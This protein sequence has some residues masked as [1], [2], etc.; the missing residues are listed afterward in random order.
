[1]ICNISSRLQH[2]EFIH[3]HKA[4]FSPSDHGKSFFNTP[5]GLSLQLWRLE[6]F[7]SLDI[8]KRRF[9][10]VLQKLLLI[11]IT[12]MNYCLN[13]VILTSIGSSSLNKPCVLIV[14]MH[15]IPVSYQAVIH[16]V[17]LP[18]LQFSEYS[19]MQTSVDKL[20]QF[21]FPPLPLMERVLYQTP[22]YY[23][24]LS[25]N[26]LPVSAVSYAGQSF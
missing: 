3:A 15:H 19:N 21:F 10:L 16:K 17:M 14:C 26:C 23:T 20:S 12:S 7:W 1:M 13:C 4:C 6:I 2:I 5:G 8:H 18:S 22:L 24:H 9:L 25:L 11:L